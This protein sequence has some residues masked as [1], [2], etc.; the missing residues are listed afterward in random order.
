MVSDLGK[1]Q[2]LDRKVARDP[3]TDDLEVGVTRSTEEGVSNVLKASLK[4]IKVLRKWCADYVIRRT[5]Y[6]LD[7]HGNPIS[8]VKPY[9]DHLLLMPLLPA[10]SE[11][12]ARM[13]EEFLEQGASETVKNRR[14]RT[15]TKPD[16]HLC[17]DGFTGFLFGPTDGP[18]APYCGFG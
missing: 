16:S 7:N 1:A 13:V 3:T 2:R 14:V 15:S 5:V 12:H 17:T 9:R 11:A 18:D 10:E 6:S 8:G 4:W